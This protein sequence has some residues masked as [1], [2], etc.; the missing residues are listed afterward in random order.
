MAT[1]ATWIASDTFLAIF[2]GGSV[3][4]LCAYVLPMLDWG[5][6]IYLTRGRPSRRYGIFSLKAAVHA[7][8]RYPALAGRDIG[9]MRRAFGRINRTHARL[10]TYI[11]YPTKL[12]ELERVTRSNGV[13]TRA[14]LENAASELSVDITSFDS[15]ADSPGGLGRTRESLRH[16]VRDWSTEGAGERARVFEPI[17]SALK[18]IS[19]EMRKSMR[20]LVPG[21]GLGRLAWEI[22]TL[23]ELFNLFLDHFPSFLLRF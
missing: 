20:V 15:S 17:I 8:A 14:I 9:A 23:G 3:I 11:G 5:A 12:D 16:L 10:A 1:A 13:L 18:E 2:L 7:Y 22:S 4:A 19:P 6:L 21:A